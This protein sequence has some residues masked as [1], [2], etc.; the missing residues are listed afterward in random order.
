M[1][2]YKSNVLHIYDI[3]NDANV[4]DTGCSSSFTVIQGLNLV[5]LYNPTQMNDYEWSSYVIAHR[6]RFD[7]FFVI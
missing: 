6:F 4:M 5:I 7:S 2:N 1:Y 3:R